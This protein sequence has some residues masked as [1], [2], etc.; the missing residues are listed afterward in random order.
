MEVFWNLF[1]LRKIVANTRK[2]LWIY[3]QRNNSVLT[4]FK[5]TVNR[6]KREENHQSDQQQDP[7]SERQPFG[8]Q[9]QPISQRFSFRQQQ[10]RK[11]FD[12]QQQQR[13]QQSVVRRH[14]QS[15]FTLNS[16]EQPLSQIR[17][18]FLRKPQ[19]PSGQSSQTSSGTIQ[20]SFPTKSSSARTSDIDS[21]EDS[22]KTSILTTF[23][24][25]KRAAQFNQ[26]FATGSN[27]QHFNCVGP[28]VIPGIQQIIGG[29]VITF[30]VA[31]LIVNFTDFF[32]CR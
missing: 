21:N 7:L 10:Q 3:F 27:S 30:P 22:V 16:H 17:Q 8:K 1:T 25:R 11:S 2:I 12:R 32:A 26:H 4:F 24:R 9:Q 18:L 31:F 15:Q 23:K 13:R 6:R 28:C 5:G 29:S 19:Q 20:T 14:Q